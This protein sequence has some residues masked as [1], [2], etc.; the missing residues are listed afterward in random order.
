MTP[1][2]CGR[3]PSTAGL[4]VEELP[5]VPLASE[6]VLLRSLQVRIAEQAAEVVVEAARLL[7]Q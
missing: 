7:P 3:C 6:L 1:R 5:A 4:A 2:S